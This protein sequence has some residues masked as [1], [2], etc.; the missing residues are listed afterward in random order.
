MNLKKN[1]VKLLSLML[2]HSRLA[3][4]F[5]LALL[6][7]SWIGLKH[8]W[9][10]AVEEGEP[11]IRSVFVLDA[12]IFRELKAFTPLV[13]TLGILSLFLILRS[14]S[15]TLLALVLVLISGCTTMALYGWFDGEI[16]SVVNF[17][18]Y[19][20]L[21][22]ALVYC[23]QFLVTYLYQRDNGLN[24]GPAVWQSLIYN[25]KPISLISLLTALAYL[26]LHFYGSIRIM[27]LGN[28][29]ALGIL[30]SYVLSLTF[31]PALI[32]ALPW[33]FVRSRFLLHEMEGEGQT[34]A[35]YRQEHWLL[36]HGVP[37]ILVN[38]FLM[39]LL[40][41]GLKL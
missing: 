35:N 6:A 31:L 18:P 16:N 38:L 39:L 32:M 1:T 19:L 3:S 27:T 4:L 5:M 24:K 36:S 12:M 37:V 34:S 29:V 7:I 20:I 33:D 21:A 9:M 8:L 17:A 23:S 30:V 11:V 2:Y 14:V 13:S 25:T 15:V 40:V 10:P 22:T 26:C 28:L 41:I